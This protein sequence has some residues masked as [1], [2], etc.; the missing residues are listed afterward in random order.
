VFGL[1]VAGDFGSTCEKFVAFHTGGQKEASLLEVLLTFFKYHPD[2]VLVRG[3]TVLEGVREAGFFVEQ[4]LLLRCRNTDTHIRSR[5]TWNWSASYTGSRR[6]KLL[7]EPDVR[8][9][10][11]TKGFLWKS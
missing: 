6:N 3:Y 2:Q 11:P 7:F 9:T 8:T 1:K 10:Q 4:H 5:S